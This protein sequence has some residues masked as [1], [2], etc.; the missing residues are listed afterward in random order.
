MAS[1][2]SPLITNFPILD[3][4]Y[5]Q[6]VPRNNILN[7]PTKVAHITMTDLWMERNNCYSLIMR[8]L[9]NN[10]PRVNF[11]ALRIFESGDAADAA[12]WNLAAEF[13]SRANNG[14]KIA[15]DGVVER[16]PEWLSR[17]LPEGEDERFQVQV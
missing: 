1:H 2:F 4:L 8:E 5:V 17:E 3:R 15:G 6:F 14:W 7:N 12:A 11:G 16:D 9:F 10:P 13:I